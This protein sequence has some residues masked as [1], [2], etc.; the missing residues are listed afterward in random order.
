LDHVSNGRLILGVGLGD[1][2]ATEFGSFGEE[3]DARRRADMLDEG[4]AVL[5][6][7]W[8]GEPFTFEGEHYQVK[9]ALCWPPPVQSPRIPIWV[10][11]WWPH[12]RPMRR[13]ARWDGVVPGK[14]IGRQMT[15]VTPDDVREII[16]YVTAHR[17]SAAPFDVAIGGT[18]PGNDPTRTADTMAQYAEAGLTWWHEGPGR[19]DASL[20]EVRARIRQGP[21]RLQ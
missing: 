6:G 17:E 21:P 20:E 3:T 16:A 1:P 12:R 10:A 7:L 14:V 5:T 9:D 18:T 4:L 19:L 2:V 8:R 15:R 13:G 11:G